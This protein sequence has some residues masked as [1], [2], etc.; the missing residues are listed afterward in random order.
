MKRPRTLLLGLVA[1]ASLV[2]GTTLIGGQLAVSAMF[3]KGDDCCVEVQGQLV[4]TITDEVL[5][6]CCCQ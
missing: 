5:E 2:A 3:P 1:L 4:C 6:E